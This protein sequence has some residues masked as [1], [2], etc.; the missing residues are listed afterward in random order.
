[1]ELEDDSSDNSSDSEEE[2]Y[3]IG[4]QNLFEWR[5]VT[6]SRKFQPKLFHFDD[7]NS[8]INPDLDLSENCTESECFKEIFDNDIVNHIAE[9][10]N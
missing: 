3:F 6:D 8:G 2:D 4:P 9:E 10:T 1:M 5:N 7:Q